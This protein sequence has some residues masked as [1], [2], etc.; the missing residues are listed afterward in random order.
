M[1]STLHQLNSEDP[2]QEKQW[3]LET[4]ISC[5]SVCV[6][7]NKTSGHIDCKGVKVDPESMDN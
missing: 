5:L 4:D 7:Q 6:H 2:G 1:I 3:T